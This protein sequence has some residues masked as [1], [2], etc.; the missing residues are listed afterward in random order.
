M[1]GTAL[2]IDRSEQTNARSLPNV[3]HATFI[4]ELELT[5]FHHGAHF[6]CNT[7]LQTGIVDAGG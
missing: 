1:Q 4:T 7:I 3:Q 6:L 5:D 2:Q